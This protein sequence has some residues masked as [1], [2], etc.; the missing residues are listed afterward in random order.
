MPPRVRP[1][2]QAEVVD[3][4]V[5]ASKMA[6]GAVTASKIASNAITTNELSEQTEVF[7]A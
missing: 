4:S 1:L 3:G 6:D 5:T 2:V 7:E